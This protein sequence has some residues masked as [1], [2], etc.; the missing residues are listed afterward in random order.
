M[1]RDPLQ[2]KLRK[3]EKKNPSPSLQDYSPNL[4]MR[5]YFL[6]RYFSRDV[7]KIWQKEHFYFGNIQ[8]EGKAIDITDLLNSYDCIDIISVESEGRPIAENMKRLIGD[9]TKN[10]ILIRPDSHTALEQGISWVEGVLTP[11][12]PTL[13]CDSF[14]ATGGTLNAVCNYLIDKGYY[15]KDLY[16]CVKEAG[17]RFFNSRLYNNIM[18]VKYSPL[19]GQ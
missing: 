12:N 15:P 3:M 6:K 16:V 17:D 19:K 4:T 14:I 8:Q 7:E 18:L 2:K 5:S 13:I 1:F 9:K 11:R 10:F